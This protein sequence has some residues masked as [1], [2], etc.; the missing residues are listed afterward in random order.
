MVLF[1]KMQFDSA[2][3]VRSALILAGRGA[4]GGLG[5]WVGAKTI[6]PLMWMGVRKLNP[7]IQVP[8]RKYSPRRS[9]IGQGLMLAGG[10]MGIPE[11]VGIGG[12]LIASDN[13]NS[14]LMKKKWVD[15]KD[16]HPSELNMI[17]YE[18]PNW[19]PSKARYNMLGSILIEL[20]TKPTWNQTKNAWIPAAR[21]HP[22]IINKAREIAQENVLDGHNK[23]AVL[24]A[25]QVYMQD[26]IKYVYDPRWLDTFA[27]PYITLKKKVEDCDGQALLS[28]AL[29]E[30]LGIPMA[31]VLLGQKDE[32]NY[33]HILSAGIVG[34]KLV[35]IE[36]I[37]I[38]GHKAPFGYVSPHIHK[39]VIP[40]P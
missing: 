13:D 5:G 38:G 25:I 16:A 4:L 39:K 19:L 29:G 22:D 7:Y 32:K 34:K 40:L 6:P 36:T 21:E 10:L 33:N 23:L 18:I 15:H 2:H 37:P 26:D 35:Y 30:A 24:R 1:S 14:V 9:R 27:H 12:G 11:V 28:A 17:R 3:P 8:I 31:L 20:L